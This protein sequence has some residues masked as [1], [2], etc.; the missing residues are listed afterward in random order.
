[1]VQRKSK[2]PSG[3]PTFSKISEE[4]RQWSALLTGEVA[5]WPKVSVKSMFGMTTF[6]RG[7]IIFGAVPATRALTSPNSVMLKF[8][9]P[10]PDLQRRIERDG[11][12]GATIGVRQKWHTFELSSPQDLRDAIG[13]FSEAFERATATRVL[14]KPAVKKSKRSRSK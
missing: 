4:M 12:I 13:W 5:Q 14:K 8:V 9:R 11:R 1:M 10:S 7:S 3:S 2:K 6:Y